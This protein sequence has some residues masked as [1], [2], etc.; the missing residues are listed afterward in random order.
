MGAVAEKAGLDI[1]LVMVYGD[2][3][4][5]LLTEE[6]LA[7]LYKAESP[8]ERRAM[9]AAV[10]G[11]T[12]LGLSAD[13]ATTQRLRDEDKVRTPE[14]LGVSRTEATRSQLAASSIA[15][16]VDWSGGLYA[17]PPRFRSW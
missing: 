4:T 8:A 3:T 9:I 11:V 12:P 7:Y 14:D 15:D 6:G 1:A 16:L 13:A 10:A 5:H 2:D 17:P